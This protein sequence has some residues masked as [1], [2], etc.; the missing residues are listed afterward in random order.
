VGARAL[1]CAV[2]I[3][4]RLP[5]MMLRGVGPET[6]WLEGSGL[7]LRDGLVCDERL[8]ARGARDVFAVGDVARWRNPRYGEETRVEHWTN[9]VETAGVAAANLVGTRWTRCQP[10][11]GLIAE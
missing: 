4:E 2:T 7:S 1:G 9:A 10:F 11:C 8:A 6:G 5:A 3:V